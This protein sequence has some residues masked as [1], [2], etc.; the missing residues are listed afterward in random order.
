M[1]HANTADADPADDKANAE[2]RWR[3]GSLA[4]RPGFLIRRLHQIHTALFNEECN[5]GRVTPIMYSLL[6]TLAQTGPLDQTTLARHIA[7][8]KTNLVEVLERM[9]K[10]GLI[11]RWRSSKDGRVRLTDLTD[12]GRQL[13]D[14]ID[15]GAQRAHRR[16]LE[17]LTAE[18]QRTFVA[19]MSKIIEAKDSP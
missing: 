10:R 15:A 14:R 1:A 17:D 6:S 9:R 7:V 19:L 2:P 4:R 8:D 11:R 18:E 3:M 12:E 13:L 16:T 5:E